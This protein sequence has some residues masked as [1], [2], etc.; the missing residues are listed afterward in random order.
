MSLKDFF[1]KTGRGGSGGPYG[2]NRQNSSGG[3]G[4]DGQN[5]SG[6]GGANG[7]G[8]P[9]GRGAKGNITNS[10]T[11][12]VMVVVT[13]WL[14]VMPAEAHTE[15]DYVYP[16]VNQHIIIPSIIVPASPRN[17]LLRFPKTL[18]KMKGVAEAAREKARTALGISLTLRNIT[19]NNRL[20]RVLDSDGNPV[21][22]YEYNL[23]GNPTAISGLS[24]DKSC[25]LKTTFTS[26]NSS[27][28]Y[29]DVIYYDGLGYPVQENAIGASPAGN[30]MITP[31][32]YDNM[33]RDDA[34][35]YLPYAASKYLDL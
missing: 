23:A 18:W 25:I 8:R 3:I 9:G 29:K 32:V 22:K 11:A 2:A 33:R 12:A 16:M 14:A 26:A 13:V 5:G 34:T 19:P 30:S 1:N 31:I 24:S 6:Q 21:S 10:L 15:P 20:Y 17:I 4:P 7:Q 28:Y 35:S 27:S